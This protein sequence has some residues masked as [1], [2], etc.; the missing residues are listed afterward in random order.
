[1]RPDPRDVPRSEPRPPARVRPAHVAVVASGRSGVG[2]SVCAALLALECAARGRRV[3]LIDGNEGHGLQHELFGVRPLRLL[4]SLRDAQ[5]AVTDVCTSL[6]DAFTVVACAPTTH[7]IRA[8]SREM[9]AMP[10]ERLLVL[11][12]DYDCVIVDGGSRLDNIRAIA[13]SGAGRAVLV[14]D[15]DSMSLAATF[16]L[17]K[18]L[19]VDAPA[20][21]G[22][23][24]VNRRDAGPAERASAQI[25]D[26]CHHFLAKDIPLAGCVPDDPSLSAAIGAGMLIGDAAQGSPAAAAMKPLALTVFPFLSDPVAATPVSPP[27]HD[28]RRRSL[29]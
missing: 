25:T 15:T 5:V 12:A 19:H 2:T 11:S 10:W 7:G 29:S 24:L 16:A 23:V 8:F 26:A 9:H 20:L 4:E 14:T 21:S 27:S 3:L 1:M 18:A 6:G 28:I 17:I 22:A 13:T